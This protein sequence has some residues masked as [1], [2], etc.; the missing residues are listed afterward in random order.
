MGENAD[1][2]FGSAISGVLDVEGDG[3]SEFAVAAPGN[4][5]AGNNKGAVY[6]V[7]TY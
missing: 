1:D 5:N 2:A 6:V 4:D 7:P 3:Q